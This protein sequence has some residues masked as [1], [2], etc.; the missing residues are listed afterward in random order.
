MLTWYIRPVSNFVFVSKVLDKVVGISG[1]PV[2]KFLPVREVSL[3]WFNNPLSE[4]CAVMYGIP[5]GSVLCALL[6]SLYMEPLGQ[7]LRSFYINFHCYADDPWTAYLPQ[8]RRR[9]IK[10]ISNQ[11]KKINLK[12][13]DLEQSWRTPSPSHTITQKV[14]KSLFIVI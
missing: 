2:A 9:T 4:P 14:T 1:P 5:H 13:V 10:L 3:C 12:K 8:S 6:F 11:S 7:I